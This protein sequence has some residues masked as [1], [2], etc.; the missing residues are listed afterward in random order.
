M[1]QTCTNTLSSDP[2][3]KCLT[4]IPVSEEGMPVLDLIIRVREEHQ[5]QTQTY[6]RWGSGQSLPKVNTA[7]YRR[8]LSD[9]GR[10]ACTG[11]KLANL[12]IKA[13]IAP[14]EY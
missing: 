14:F 2:L 5:K 11:M 8:S 12:E 6:L 1:I 3:H 10:H 13:V 4:G 9:V 7:P